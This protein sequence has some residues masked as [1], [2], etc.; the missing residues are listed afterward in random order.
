MQVSSHNGFALEK[1]KILFSVKLR[2]D[3]PLQLTQSGLNTKAHKRVHSTQNQA[4]FRLAGTS[5]A[6]GYIYTTLS[7]ESTAKC[8]WNPTIQK[9]VGLLSIELYCVYCCFSSSASSS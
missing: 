3:L 4:W 2:W 1:I 9:L 8:K 5:N 7:A 6:C